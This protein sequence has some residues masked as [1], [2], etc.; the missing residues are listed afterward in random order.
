ML[1]LSWNAF[2]SLLSVS[3]NKLIVRM[4]VWETKYENNWNVSNNLHC[5]KNVRIW[6]FSGPN[7]RKYGP[8][9]LP[10]R[11]LLTQCSPNENVF[12][13]AYNL[14]HSISKLL[15]HYTLNSRSSKVDRKNPDKNHDF[16]QGGSELS[17][18]EGIT[19]LYLYLQPII[20]T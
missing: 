19:S 16:I 20:T 6:N 17:M 8:E 14:C 7:A 15:S 11:T 4:K 18:T 13:F 3:G 12:D 9:K 10:I 5:L 1:Q 2:S